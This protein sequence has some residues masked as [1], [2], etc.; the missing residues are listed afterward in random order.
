MG[1]DR[2][3]MPVAEHAAEHVLS[4]PVHPALSESDLD[5]IVEAVRKVAATG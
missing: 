1:Y 4:L 3:S 5:R 2:V